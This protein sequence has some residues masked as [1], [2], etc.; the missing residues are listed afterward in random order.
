MQSPFLHLYLSIFILRPDQSF[1]THGKALD[2]S[3]CVTRYPDARR[4]RNAYVPTPSVPLVPKRTQ[5]VKQYPPNLVRGQE[6]CRRQ[7]MSGIPTAI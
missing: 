5:E 1:K 3:A 6:H 2:I 7:D 4:V